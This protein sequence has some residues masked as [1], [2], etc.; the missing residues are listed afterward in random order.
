M[1]QVFGHMNN[2]DF[3]IHLSTAHNAQTCTHSCISDRIV[4]A[5]HEYW[6]LTAHGVGHRKLERWRGVMKMWAS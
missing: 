4:R 6:L 5:N 2:F 3:D 1:L